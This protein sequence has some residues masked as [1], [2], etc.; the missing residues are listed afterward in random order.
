MSDVMPF[1]SYE[2]CGSAADWLVRAFAFEEVDRLEEDGVVGHVTL[3]SGD[4]LI[5]LGH[6]GP[7]YVCPRR[8]RA[9]VEVAARMYDVPWVIVGVLV[10]ADDLDEHC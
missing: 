3:R 4:G 8:L 1:L 5:L 10:L 6:P 2:D 7:D 9:T